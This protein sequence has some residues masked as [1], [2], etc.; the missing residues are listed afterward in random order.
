MNNNRTELNQPTQATRIQ[1]IDLLRGIVMIIMALDHVRDYFHVDAFLFAPLDLEKTY[2]ALYATRWVTHFCA[3]V[4]VFLAGT[5]AYLVGLRKN[6]RELSS[7]LI[8]RGLWIIFLEFTLI[9]FSWFFNI[10][11][12]FIALSVIWALGVSM[13]ALSLAIH[14]P[15]KFILVIGFVLVGGHNLLDAYHVEGESTWAALWKLLHDPGVFQFSRFV[16][17]VGYPLIPWIGIMLMGYCFGVLYSPST[18]PLFRKKRLYFLGFSAIVLFLI[19]RPTNLYGDPSPWAL[20]SSG[21]LTFLSFMKVSKYPPSLLYILI[22]LGPALLFLARSEK[23]AGRL[24][25][26]IVALGR[27]PMFYYIVHIYVIHL[28]A[29]VAALATGFEASDMVFNTWVT[30]SPNLKGY[31][32]SLSTVYLIWIGIVLALLPL[33]LWYDRY[34]RSHRDKWW[35]SY[36]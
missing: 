1:S 10:H 33:C 31:G 13:I 11:F 26:M 19:M 21:M 27:V 7:F 15:I 34:K 30:D 12:S 28:L 25:S 3:P 18:D 4:F 36:M 23:Y 29:L 8:K 35:L 2:P 9:N 14:L 6:K 16:V 17:F 22:T 24:V 5:S 20:H 32:F